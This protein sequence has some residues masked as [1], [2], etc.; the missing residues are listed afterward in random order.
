MS[1]HESGSNG[2]MSVLPAGIW[3]LPED[4]TVVLVELSDPS[5]E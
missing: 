4:W 2:V 3:K 5:E 1:L